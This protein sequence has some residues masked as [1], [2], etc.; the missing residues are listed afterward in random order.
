MGTTRIRSR[1]GNQYEA[2]GRLTIKGQSRDVDLP[3]TLSIDGNR[4]SMR[5]QTTIDRRDYGIG[6]G[7]TGDDLISREVTITVRVDADR[8]R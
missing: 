8:A 6:N 2:R 3:F 4:A 5:G 1:G 7:G